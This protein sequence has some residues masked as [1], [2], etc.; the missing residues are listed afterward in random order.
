MFLKF[1]FYYL[2]TNPLISAKSKF[3]FVNDFSVPVYRPTN[4]INFFKTR[5]YFNSLEKLNIPQQIVKWLVM[6]GYSDEDGIK[7]DLDNNYER[8]VK[9]YNLDP[10][11]FNKEDIEKY[12]KYLPLEVTMDYKNYH[13]FLTKVKNIKKN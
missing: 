9:L 4:I 13:W 5:D 12:S 2:F 11:I 3:W 1:L 10:I 8:K 6:F 7:P